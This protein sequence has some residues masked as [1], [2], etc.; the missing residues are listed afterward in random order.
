MIVLGM[1]QDT[2]EV[3]LEPGEIFEVHLPES[4]ASSGYQWEVT[5]RPAGV[6]LVADEMIPP[7]TGRPGA[8]GERRLRFEASDAPSGALVLELR[9][10]WERGVAP[11]KSFRVTA[12]PGHTTS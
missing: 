7:G 10:S 11:E 8:A 5:E 9:R 3:E 1:E 12:V 4:A 2:S 6:E